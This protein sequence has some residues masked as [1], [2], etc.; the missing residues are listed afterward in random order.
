MQSDSPRLVPDNDSKAKSFTPVQAY[1]TIVLALAI[2]VMGIAV[3][4]KHSP[5]AAAVATIEIALD[6]PWSNLESCNE[7]LE[8][9]KQEVFS[10][11][12]MLETVDLAWNQWLQ[13]RPS[14]QPLDREGWARWLEGALTVETTQLQLEDYV[15]VSLSASGSS[16]PFVPHLVNQAALSL[17]TYVDRQLARDDIYHRWANEQIQ[18]EEALAERRQWLEKLEQTL[19]RQAT[20]LKVITASN[21]SGSRDA[22]F[23]SAERTPSNLQPLPI[24][25]DLLMAEIQMKTE[26]LVRLTNERLWQAGHP[27]RLTRLQE[28]DTLKRTAVNQLNAIGRSPQDYPILASANEANSTNGLA[29]IHRNEFYPENSDQDQQSQQASLA[30][31]DL[32]STTQELDQLK[33]TAA[34]LLL[35][36]E[37]LLLQWTSW[38]DGNATPTHARVLEL[39]SGVPATGSVIRSSHWL[40]LGLMSSVLAMAFGWNLSKQPDR[41]FTTDQVGD[42]L[43]LPVLGIVTGEGHPPQGIWA[44]L[45]R[46]ERRI[47]TGCEVVLLGTLG[48]VLLGLLMDP[49]LFEVLVDHPLDGLARSMQLVFG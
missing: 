10:H 21:T 40:L 25:L 6:P 33:S 20:G 18:L 19:E 37:R 16:D 36:E 5:P 13:D 8:D 32:D 2:L 1:R 9:A 46:H 34:T 23:V 31:A 38:L 7:L 22:T 3:W 12:K 4:P 35:D 41:F 49:R 39:A 15:Q 43:G 14:D 45:K 30:I 24:E 44:T 27:E 29:T 11:E 48:I 17:S 26:E 47:Q 28:I 42:S